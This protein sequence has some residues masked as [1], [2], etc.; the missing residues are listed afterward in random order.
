MFFRIQSINLKTFLYSCFFREKYS[1]FLIAFSVL[2]WVSTSWLLLVYCLVIV[3]YDLLDCLNKTAFWLIYFY[4]CKHSDILD[5]FNA[6]LRGSSDYWISLV[7]L[8]LLT[9]SKECNRNYLSILLH[10]ILIFAFIYCYTRFYQLS[11]WEIRWWCRFLLC[12]WG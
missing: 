5:E 2:F 1:I 6:K 7:F 3:S 11:S 4:S 10:W 12:S 8:I 9:L